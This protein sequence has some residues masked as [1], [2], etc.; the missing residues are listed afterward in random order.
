MRL[1][2]VCL[3]LM[4]SS[5]ALADATTRPSQALFDP[6]RHMRVSEVRPGMTGYGLSVFNGTTIDKFD[7]EVVSV[8][9]NF[10]PKH[11]VILVK[12]RGQNLEHTGAVG[13]MSGS[14][15]YLTDDQGR[16]RLAGAFAYGFPMAK[17]P[18]G[19]VQ[20][21][22]YML[23]LPAEAREPSISTAKRLNASSKTP[24]Q[25]KIRWSLG[26]TVMLPSMTAAPT[27]LPAGSYR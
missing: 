17:D 10:N 2:F 27:G 1:I 20:P 9:H 7:V 4:L 14:P 5:S 12:C 6:A 22:E 13:G 24:T 26:D 23:Q 8:L 3:L 16:K 15:I 25:Q 18:I 19:G 21:I 11:D